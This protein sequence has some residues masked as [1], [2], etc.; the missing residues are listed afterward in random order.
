M[1]TLIHQ[2]VR[3]AREG[4]NPTVVCRMASGW[5]VF[6]DQQVVPAQS[7]L[8]P[9]PVVGDLNQLDPAGRAVYLRDMVLLGD[10][11][12]EVTD[13][14]RINYEILGNAEPALHAHV[15]PRYASEPAA[16][17]R[18]PM[19]NYAWADAPPFDL[20]RDRPV[21]QEM[22]TAIARLGGAAAD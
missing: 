22:A 17:R 1:P 21:M 7:I 4:E 10:A 19:W 8:L 13:A 20:E 16:L 12:L 18:G 14:E 3:A 9:D 11:L 15:V 2:R 6:C 5:V